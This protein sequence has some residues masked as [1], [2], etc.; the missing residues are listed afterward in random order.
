MAVSCYRDAFSTTIMSGIRCRR[1]CLSRN[2]T[3]DFPASHRDYNVTVFHCDIDGL[4]DDG[5]SA[6]VFAC[7]ALDVKA[8]G[9]HGVGVAQGLA[10]ADVELPTMPW[11]TDHFARA[12]EAVIARAGRNK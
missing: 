7:S 3:D 5:P 9:L 8:F 6:G 2:Y 11:A 12:G 1:R 10:C 4:G